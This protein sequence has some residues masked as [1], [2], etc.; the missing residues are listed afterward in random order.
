[1]P[2]SLFCVIE[3]Y[4]KETFIPKATLGKQRKGSK[5]S[6]INP[7]NEMQITAPIRASDNNPPRKPYP[8]MIPRKMGPIAAAACFQLKT[9]APISPRPLP[10]PGSFLSP[11]G[12]KVPELEAQKALDFP[13]APG[14]TH[15]T[16]FHIPHPSHGPGNTTRLC[17]AA[18]SLS[19]L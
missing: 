9:E 8:P 17:R 2:P 3:K 11:G 1:M 13:V 5:Q 7:L 4:S 18:Q 6:H 12:W 10:P 15:T 14:T 16:L 19:R